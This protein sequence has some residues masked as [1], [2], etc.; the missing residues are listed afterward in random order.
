MKLY[1]MVFSPTGGTKKVADILAEAMGLER[2]I[3]DLT[4]RDTAFSEICLSPEDVCL[5]AVPSYGGRV[6]EA[7]SARLR[8]IQ[9]K[10]AKAVLVCVYGNRA[11][12]DTLVELK[13]VMTEAGFFCAAAVSAVA[14]HS[15]ARQFAAGRPDGADEKELKEFAARIRPL[16]TGEAPAEEAE[17]PGNRP[18]R[19]L[20]VIP[21][22]PEGGRECSGCGSC[23]KKCPVGAIPADN[24]AKTD[25]SLC[26]SCMRCIKVCP[27]DARKLNKLMLA[28]VSQ[29]L[30]KVCQEPKK[31]E[32]FLGRFEGEN[33]NS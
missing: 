21:M 28:A 6:P 7:A 18:Y 9:G 15:I 16:L 20:G 14:E 2:Q 11:Y 8:Q 32:L 24:P 33:G 3:V 10:G 29:K 13:D 23:V 5:A 25:A 31:N 17:V 27:R 1:E 30:K 22:H 26:I 12:E 4:K 19:K